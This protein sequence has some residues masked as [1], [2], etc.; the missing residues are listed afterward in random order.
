MGIR[1]ARCYTK[2]VGSAYTRTQGRKNKGYIRGIPGSKIVMY[3][4]GNKSG[5]FEIEVHMVAKEQCIIRHM[6]IEAAR[7][8]INRKAQ[9]VGSD[10]YHFRIR[11]HPYH[12]LREN[13]MMAFAGADRMQDGMRQSFGKPTDLAARVRK[14]QELFTVAM[15]AKNYK[16]AV[17]ALKAGIAKMPCPAK[18]TFGKGQELIKF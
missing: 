17:A 10:S 3:D 16:M 4:M 11:V 18:I 6:A 15:D 7:Q 1:P 2:L 9:I 5:K 8:A 13:K 14:N 12:V